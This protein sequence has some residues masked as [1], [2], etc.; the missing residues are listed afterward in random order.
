MVRILL[1]CKIEKIK[2]LDKVIS[3]GLEFNL[4]EGEVAGLVGPSG[5]GKTTLCKLFANVLEESNWVDVVGD[6]EWNFSSQGRLDKLTDVDRTL[7]ICLVFQNPEKNFIS[8][9]VEGEF[10]A[11]LQLCGLDR[12][13]IE[14]RIKTYVS[15]LE[16]DGLLKKRLS[17]LSGG[18]KQIVSLATVLMIQPKLLVLDEP[19]AQLSNRNEKLF[20]EQL[21]EYVVNNS[22]AA[23]VTT[24]KDYVLDEYCSKEFRIGE[25]VESQPKIIG[26]KDL[27]KRSP[28]YRFNFPVVERA[29]QL[30]I[31]NVCIDACAG[32]CFLLLGDN[33]SGKTT[34]LEYICG[35]LPE[36]LF[37]RNSS[38]FPNERQYVFQNPDHQLFTESLRQ[39]LELGFRFSS[40]S[41]QERAARLKFFHDNLAFASG[42]EDVD[43]RT[44]S[45][46]QKKM[47]N[48]L[49][50][51]C[52]LREAGGVLLLDEPDL[53]LDSNNIFT[54]K[55]L[56]AE[57]ISNGNVVLIVTHNPQIY[58][59]L[60][61]KTIRIDSKKIEL[62]N[63]PIL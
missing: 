11:S 6:V 16:I 51:L 13:V 52:L 50:S 29:G 15:R 40:F 4:N 8:D 59:G 63:D 37:K 25:K 24:H 38:F 14:R 48:I 60:C 34:L 41:E 23:I 22:A 27:K 42:D 2:L 19:T 31:K 47:V 12:E 57:F 20:F 28:L 44:L 26:F 62:D 9:S 17:D 30:L 58:K 55:F 49:I 5:S 18:E 54:L 43:P 46:G 21:R 56:L 39:E 53:A 61:N 3:Y 1:S 36:S 7:D 10:Y 45:W 33:G 32:D 35:F